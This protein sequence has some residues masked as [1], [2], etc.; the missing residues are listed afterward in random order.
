MSSI[1][2]GNFF[3]FHLA[4]FLNTSRASL[5]LPR[6]SSQRGDST[7][8]GTNKNIYTRG[9]RDMIQYKYLQWVLIGCAMKGETITLPCRKRNRIGQLGLDIY[10]QPLPSR[11]RWNISHFQ[12]GQSHLRTGEM[13]ISKHLVK[14]RRRKW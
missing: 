10:C 8:K 5:F 12:N 13:N 4:S 11:G 7:T 3:L 9:G 1:L 6:T 2:S 14:G